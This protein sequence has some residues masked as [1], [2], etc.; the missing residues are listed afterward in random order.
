MT[1]LRKMSYRKILEIGSSA[2][3]VIGVFQDQSGDRKATYLYAL[4]NTTID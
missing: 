4:Y 2:F 1:F 3:R